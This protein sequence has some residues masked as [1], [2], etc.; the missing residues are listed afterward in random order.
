[1]HPN[2]SFSPSPALWRARL[3]RAHLVSG[4]GGLF[5]F[6]ALGLVLESLHAFKVDSYLNADHEARRLLWRLAHA[7]G[8]LLSLVQIAFAWTLTRLPD[9]HFPKPMGLASGSLTSAWL[10]LPGGFFL[11]GIGATSADPSP[12]ILLVPLGGLLLLF[13]LGSTAWCAFGL[14]PK[15]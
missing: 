10:L 7:H 11:G 6:A 3:V 15:P 8:T 5:L 13:G 2:D 4:W 14:T 12:A 9:T 1:M